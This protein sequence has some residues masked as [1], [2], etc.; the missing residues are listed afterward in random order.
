MRRVWRFSPN[1]QLERQETR[2]RIASH[3]QQ[4]AFSSQMN[5][6]LAAVLIY[7]QVLPVIF[8]LLLS[9]PALVVDPIDS[10]AFRHLPFLNTLLVTWYTHHPYM[11]HSSW[12][13]SLNAWHSSLF[14]HPLSLLS[15][16]TAFSHTN[17]QHLRKMMSWL[18]TNV[19]TVKGSNEFER[20]SW[21]PFFNISIFF[22]VR[23]AWNQWNRWE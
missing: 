13:R 3:M 9:I 10:C 18:L 22:R 2:I 7:L 11:S 19:K 12:C 20:I 6:V 8:H 5:Q 1:Q 14:S 4:L 23:I 16:N 17:T 21:N 15:S